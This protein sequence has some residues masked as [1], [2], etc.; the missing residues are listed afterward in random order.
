MGSLPLN[1]LPHSAARKSGAQ[2]SN[3]VPQP[4]LV[5]L[6]GR[7]F[8]EDL[9]GLHRACGGL[10]NGPHLGRPDGPQA[11][12][13]GRDRGHAREVGEQ[14]GVLAVGWADTL[15]QQELEDAGRRIGEEVLRL[16]RRDGL[17]SPRRHVQ[18]RVGLTVVDHVRL[19]HLGTK[20]RVEIVALHDRLP[21][22][23]VEHIERRRGPVCVD[24]E[25]LA[26]GRRS[27]KGDAV[28]VVGASRQV[29]D[30]GD[31]LLLQINLVKALR[32][33]LTAVLSNDHLFVLG[34]WHSPEPAG[35]ARAEVGKREVLGDLHGD[36][37]HDR[38][39]TLGVGDEVV[40]AERAN[41]VGAHGDR[42]GG[43]SPAGRRGR[44]HGNRGLVEAHAQG[45]VE[46]ELV[47]RAA[48]HAVHRARHIH[49]HK[50]I[51]AV[52]IAG[53]DRTADDPRS[54]VARVEAHDHLLRCRAQDVHEL[55]AR[56]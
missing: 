18:R 20:G 7:A 6:V 38:A 3:E 32:P 14:E 16:D 27:A 2:P 15:G 56:V 35:R 48:R 10:V 21:R 52:P 8:G 12:H 30:L 46:K 47:Q 24:E 49:H 40:V 33:R 22:A 25:I 23:V 51:L 41:R 42:L 36:D 28:R 37:V 44:A 50:L 5:G 4:S 45:E 34:V 55:V 11:V 29:V 26:R 43:R 13:V 9:V 19:E 39:G 1:R 53:V 31:R 54:R 17:R